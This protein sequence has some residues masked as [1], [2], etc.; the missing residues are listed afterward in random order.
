MPH[1]QTQPFFGR[2]ARPLGAALAR[3]ATL[4]SQCA[5]CHGWGSGRICAACVQRF[6]GALP[7]HPAAA[8]C[9]GCALRVPEGKRVCGAC[10]REPPPFARTLAGV[11]YVHPWDR[12]I[13]HFKFH[14]ALDL[15]PALTQRLLARFDA[16]QIPAPTLLLPVPLSRARLRVRGYNQAWELARR[17]GRALHCPAEPDLLL[18]V[19]DTPHQLALAP[20]QRAANVRG[21]FAIEPRRLAGVR[22]CRVALVD[23]VMTTGA[24]AAEISRVLLRAGAAEVSVWVIARTPR[25]ED[26]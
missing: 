13:T 20:Q 6:G 10:L 25:P 3:V 5:I 4:P 23:D 12:L 9:E 2:L 19:K 17:L 18:R 22:G 24:T 26:G 7:G 1:F 11:D 21:A 14:D 16:A 15:A 8:R